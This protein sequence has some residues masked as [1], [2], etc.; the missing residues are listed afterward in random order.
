[1][2]SLFQ[3]PWYNWM[4]RS[5]NRLLGNYWWDADKQKLVKLRF[6]GDKERSDQQRP[7][8]NTSMYCLTGTNS[9][10]IVIAFSDNG[11]LFLTMAEPFLTVV[12]PFLTVAEPFWHW[13]NLFWQWQSLFGHWQILFWQWWNLFWQWQSIFLKMAVTKTIIMC[14]NVD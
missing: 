1:M 11:R 2:F 14:Q 3:V 4:L 7:K 6:Y 5:C 10:H 9:Q 12:E 8:H 13:Q